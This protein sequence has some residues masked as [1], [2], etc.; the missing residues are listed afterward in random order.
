VASMGKLAQSGALSAALAHEFSQPL[1]SILLNV[2]QSLVLLQDPANAPALP[3]LLARVESET[4][5]AAE[6]LKQVKAM[7]RTGP[8]KLTPV[9]PNEVLGFVV[10]MMERSLREAG[11]AVEVAQDARGTVMFSKG[12]LEHVLLNLL[13]NAMQALRSCE[14]AKRRIRVRTWDE[15]GQVQVAVHD[16]GPGIA[17]TLQ[18][19]I[20]NL[21]FSTKRQNMGMGLWLARYLMERHDGRIWL[22][23]NTPG[24]CEFVLAMP[25]VAAGAASLDA[26]SLVRG[27]ESNTLLS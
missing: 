3:P 4:L 14:G 12:Q 1:S 23:R 9:N 15:G 6:T 13:H 11:V 19:S 5:R 22:A 24:H 7:F 27:I 18:D 21:S 20:F 26:K 8:P 17:A 25:A 16:N 10:A 2:Q